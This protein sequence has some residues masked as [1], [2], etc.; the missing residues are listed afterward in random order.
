M[1]LRPIP[2]TP[3]NLIIIRRD[4]GRRIISLSEKS[5]LGG[6]WFARRTLFLPLKIYWVLWVLRI[7]TGRIQI[8]KLKNKK[9]KKKKKK[10]N[11]FE[12]ENKQ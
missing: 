12:E 3:D 2:I 9:K 1:S 8:E 6:T 11:E 7:R 4:S 5:G 10:R